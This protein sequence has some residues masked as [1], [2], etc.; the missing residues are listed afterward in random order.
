MS[1][2]KLYST[3]IDAG[4]GAKWYKVKTFKTVKETNEFLKKYPDFGFLKELKTY[5]DKPV[6][7]VV[8]KDDF[9]VD[10]LTV[11]F[12]FEDAGFCQRYYRAECGRL[13]V[14]VDGRLH[15]CNDDAWKEPC[16]PVDESLFNI[17]EAANA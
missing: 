16:T 17:V 14:V 4:L 6:Y 3:R 5:D 8:K 12:D 11:T 2:L 10:I 15:T 9:G 1:K 13:F 7:A